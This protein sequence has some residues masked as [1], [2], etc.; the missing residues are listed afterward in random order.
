MHALPVAVI[1]KAMP[2]DEGMAKEVRDTGYENEISPSRNKIEK[3][4]CM[5]RNQLVNA[6]ETIPGLAQQHVLTYS[7][8]FCLCRR[9]A[10]RKHGCGQ[11]YQTSTSFVSCLREPC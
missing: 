7:P 10:D 8:C 2:A 11:L 6:V 5:G 4:A 3:R 9:V 1:L